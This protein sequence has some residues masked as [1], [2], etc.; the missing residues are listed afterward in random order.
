MG[1]KK[2]SSK[3]NYTL[4]NNCS[5]R[6]YCPTNDPIIPPCSKFLGND[7][8]FLKDCMWLYKNDN[9]VYSFLS[10]TPLDKAS[11]EATL[12]TNIQINIKNFIISYYISKVQKKSAFYDTNVEIHS[13]KHINNVI[14]Q[15][16]KNKSKIKFPFASFL[17]LIVSNSNAILPLID[18]SEDITQLNYIIIFILHNIDRHPGLAFGNNNYIL[19]NYVNQLLASLNISIPLDK[20]KI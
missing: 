4:K 1:N 20:L 3:D 13:N 10:T 19:N 11:M 16:L 18:F 17:R 15:L 2:C 8:P 9:R 7:V 14:H 6:I 5:Q 12:C